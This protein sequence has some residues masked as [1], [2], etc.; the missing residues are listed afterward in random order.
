[1]QHAIQHEISVKIDEDPVFYSSLKER[2]EEIIEMYT[3]NRIDLAERI[4][5]L[6]ALYMEI[7]ERPSVARQ[8]G[9]NSAELAFYN[10]FKEDLNKIGVEDEREIVKFTYEILE[11]IEPY[12][13][14]IDWSKK[15]DTLRQ[16][17]KASKEVLFLKQIDKNRQEPLAHQIEELAKVHFS[18]K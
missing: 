15:P 1:M 5:R 10:L 17:R 14:L 2:L 18:S 13:S 4:I 11:A 3:Q 16:I 6:K 9:L 7:K 12:V 8:L